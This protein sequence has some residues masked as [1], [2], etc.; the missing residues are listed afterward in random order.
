[1]ENTCYH[2]LCL[3]QLK[4]VFKLIVSVNEMNYCYFH[5]LPLVWLTGDPP[6]I[7]RVS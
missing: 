6:S 2:M 1:M 3:C 7:K 5:Y 4:I